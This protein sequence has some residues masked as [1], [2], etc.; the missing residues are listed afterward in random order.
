VEIAE[1]IAALR[2][3]GDAMAKAAGA[4]AASARIP[5][6]P[7]WTMR[8]LVLHQGEVHRWA[9]AH[10]TGTAG[11][12]G[13]DEQDFVGPLP[14][15]EELVEWFRDG[16]GALVDALENAPADLDCWTFMKAPS[17]LAF[18]SR[19]QCHETAIHRAD[20]ES[21]SGAIT[22]FDPAVAADGIDE[23]LTCFITRP[24]SRLRSDVPRSLAVRTTDT[25]DAWVVRFSDHV[26]T[27]RGEGDADCTITAAASNLYLF[28]WNR[29][30]RD[31]ITVDGDAS[32]LDTWRAGVTIRWG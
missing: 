21:A 27:E 4:V 18:W 10:V 30:D 14:S 1:H 11:E 5:T 19:R 24:K 31:A 16:H 3:H 22:P 7:E 17:P 2:D 8:D 26:D 15:D 20:A 23:L 13:A 25:A 9:T 6:C 29:L 32:I 28:V 12:P